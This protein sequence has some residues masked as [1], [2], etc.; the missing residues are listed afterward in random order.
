MPP[1]QITLLRQSFGKVLPLRDIAA[2]LFDA[3]LFEID[4]STRPMFRGD[5][6]VQSAKLMS[7]LGTAV[8]SLDRLDDML[9]DLRSLARWHAHYGVT[10]SQYASA[11]AALLWALE[12]S[13]GPDFTPEM[14]E[15]WAS[16]YHLVAGVMMETGS[17][18][19]R[20]AA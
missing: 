3:R 10:N 4:P 12:R 5:L 9:D 6:Q 18:T 13:V 7:T 2:Q 20:G 15:A 14:R 17:R 8:R 11:G 1:R 16:L 19:L